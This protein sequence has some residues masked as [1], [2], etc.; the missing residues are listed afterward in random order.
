MVA[1]FV[2][3]P[4]APNFTP[5]ATSI[6]TQQPSSQPTA[7]PTIWQTYN[8]RWESLSPNSNE[9][10]FPSSTLQLAP[11]LSRTFKNIS[12]S[13]SS[14]CYNSTV[15]KLN[16]ADF[17]AQHLSLWLEIGIA[18]N[19]PQMRLPSQQDRGLV[20]A[21]RRHLRKES[22]RWHPDTI[23]RRTGSTDVPLDT[24]IAEREEIKGIWGGLSELMDACD[25]FLDS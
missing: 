5:T 25:A 11:L 13:T 20:E 21:A 8:S 22:M 9:F 2:P 14:T 10:P 15:I 23:D 1:N 17:F 7:T 16:A 12:P 4:T 6:P 24:S 3:R 18:K 19:K